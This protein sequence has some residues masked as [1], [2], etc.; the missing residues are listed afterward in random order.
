[1]FKLFFWNINNNLLCW[2]FNLIRYKIISICNKIMLACVDKTLSNYIY[3][4]YINTIKIWLKQL[5]QSDQPSS[6]NT[7]KKSGLVF[8]IIIWNTSG[9]VFRTL[10]L[11]AS[12]FFYKVRCKFFFK[13]YVWLVLK[14]I[15][16]LWVDRS[17]KRHAKA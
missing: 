1:M 15:V 8:N 11:S 12:F 2:S 16:L 10:V 17:E 7:K 3:W 4:K 13:V 14:M 9:L 5:D 6:D